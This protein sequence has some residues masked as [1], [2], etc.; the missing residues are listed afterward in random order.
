M[1][2][3]PLPKQLEGTSIPDEKLTGFCLVSIL[4]GILDSEIEMAHKTV[5][6]LI[7]FAHIHVY[8]TQS[9]KY[10]VRYYI[11]DHEYVQFVNFFMY[12]S[13]T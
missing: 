2:C 5:Q 7:M 12:G 10:E 4:T 9:Q 1:Q 3:Y 6:D 8:I 13:Q 11:S